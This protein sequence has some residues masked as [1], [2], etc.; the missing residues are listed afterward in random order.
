MNEQLEKRL[1]SF[2]WRLGMMLLA[3]T[4]D[5]TAKNLGDFEI[6][7]EITVI[8]GLVLGEVSKLLNSRTA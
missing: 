2:A 8:L 5:F 3:V 1:K 6:S 7:D 4:L